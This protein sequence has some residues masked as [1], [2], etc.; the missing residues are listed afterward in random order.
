MSASNFPLLIKSIYYPDHHNWPQSRATQ[1]KVAQRSRWGKGG[2][3]CQ[4]FLFSSLSQF[5]QQKDTGGRKREKSERP[6]MHFSPPPLFYLPVS[7]ITT[8]MQLTNTGMTSAHSHSG[9]LIAGERVRI[10]FKLHTAEST[11]RFQDSMMWRYSHH[12]PIKSTLM[13]ACHSSQTYQGQEPRASPL[14]PRLP[15]LGRCQNPSRACENKVAGP[16]P[17]ILSQYSWGWGW[18]NMHF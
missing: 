6:V 16:P 2:R 14:M 18:D 17:E 5:Y 9:F 3:K 12:C 4:S 1:W 10:R 11:S 7:S 13:G 15:P 8:V